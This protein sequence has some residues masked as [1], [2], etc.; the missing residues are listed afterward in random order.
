MHDRAPEKITGE[1]DESLDLALLEP[2]PSGAL[3]LAG[4][5]VALLVIACFVMYVFLFI[6]RGPVG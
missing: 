6:P 1:A 5:A 4:I 2:A 3:A